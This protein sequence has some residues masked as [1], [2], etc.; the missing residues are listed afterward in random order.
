MGNSCDTICSLARDV[1][2]HVITLLGT[3]VETNFAYKEMKK[4]DSLQPFFYGFFFFHL[5]IQRVDRI[6]RTGC[7]RR[8]EDLTGWG[9]STRKNRGAVDFGER[10]FL[11]FQET[12]NSLWLKF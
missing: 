11:V 7:Q 8:T 1:C 10:E 9:V 12:E 2:R 3:V 4:I 6:A 5:I